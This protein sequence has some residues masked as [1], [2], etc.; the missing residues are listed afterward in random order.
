MTAM[1]SMLI[2]AALLVP[3]AALA[4]PMSAQSLLSACTGDAMAKANCEGYLQALG[5]LLSRRETAGKA[6]G[7]ICLPATIAPDQL[8]G[9]VVNFAAQKTNGRLPPLALGLANQAMQLTWPCD[10]TPKSQ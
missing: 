10:S 1:K 4:A 6:T 2:A 9:A 8:R 5:D 7:R 3:A